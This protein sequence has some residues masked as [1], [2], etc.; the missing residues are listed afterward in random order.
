MD[1]KLRA[2]LRQFIKWQIKNDM[3]KNELT[4]D[5]EVAEHYLHVSDKKLE[6]YI[7]SDNDLVNPNSCP[8]RANG[9][10]TA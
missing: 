1:M 7:Q 5:Y 8:F 3:L 10:C 2:A 6:D 4:I 9:F